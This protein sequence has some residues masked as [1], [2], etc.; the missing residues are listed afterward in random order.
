MEALG[1]ETWVP[2]T[3][4]VDDGSMWWHTL[5][6]VILE[7]TNVQ[8]RPLDLGKVALTMDPHTLESQNATST[9]YRVLFCFVFHFRL[10]E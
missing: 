1:M 4:G 9:K 6:L 8:P 10:I 3:G 7:A 5:H 2:V